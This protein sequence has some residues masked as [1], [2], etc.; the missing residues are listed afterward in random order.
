MNTWPVVSVGPEGVGSRRCGTG[1]VAS[2]RVGLLC[3]KVNVGGPCEMLD[4]V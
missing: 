4:A 2:R 3:K 1:L